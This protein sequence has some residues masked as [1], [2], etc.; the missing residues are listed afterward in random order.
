[1]PTFADFDFELDDLTMLA[2]ADCLERM[3]TTMTEDIAQMIKGDGTGEL[4][5]DEIQWM[6]E[7]LI[8][9]IT[10][11]QDPSGNPDL[12]NIERSGNTFRLQIL[13]RS[14]RDGY[15]KEIVQSA[16]TEAKAKGLSGQT[17]YDAIQAYIRTHVIHNPIFIASAPLIAEAFIRGISEQNPSLSDLTIFFLKKGIQE[18]YYSFGQSAIDG[19]SESANDIRKPG[20]LKGK[21]DLLLQMPFSE[22]FFELMK[23]SQSFNKTLTVI[24]DKMTNFSVGSAARTAAENFYNGLA[25]AKQQLIAGEITPALFKSKCMGLCD[26]AENSE[27][28]NHREWKGYVGRIAYI[29][30]KIATLGI[31]NGLS[32]LLTGEAELVNINTDSINKVHH[33]R[34]TLDRM[35]PSIDQIIHSSPSE[36]PSFFDS[37]S[38]PPTSSVSSEPGAPIRK[39]SK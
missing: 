16:I 1:M 24:Q 12:F 31:I 19:L 13:D 36:K 14:T 30:L 22:D 25:E 2:V 21:L 9:D 28:K 18:V 6:K 8:S 3:P 33:I 32:R 15:K 23:A 37:P 29:V 11:T 17:L 10:I 4:S 5:Q 39:P 38:S 34:R 7:A 35:N 27:L 20:Y 26:Q